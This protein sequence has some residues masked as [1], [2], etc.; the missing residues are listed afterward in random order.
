[1]IKYLK[2]FSLL[3]VAVLVLFAFSSCEKA[4][5]ELSD[6]MI[7]QGIGVDYEKGNYTVTVEIL[8][9]EQ[10]GSPSG[11]SASDNKTKIYSM[12][13]ETV[14]DALRLL[15][16]KSGNLPLFA[17][18]RVI[19]VN[20]NLNE[21]TISDVLEFFVRNYDSRASQLVC[22][23]KGKKAEDIIRA[24]LMN[25]TVKS[26]ILENL[27]TES[28]EHS[29]IPQVRVIDAVNSLSNKAM[30]LCIPA[31]SIKKNGE[32]E[33]YELA[34]CAIYDDKGKVSKFLTSE[35]AEGIAFLN[36]D[37]KEGFFTESL[38][39]GEKATFIINKSKTRFD[40]T[41][42]NGNLVYHLAVDISCDLDETGEK[43]R[44][45]KDAEILED[46]K[47]TVKSAV[48]RRVEGTLNALKKTDGGDCVRYCKILELKKPELYD[49]VED[50]WANIFI[51]AKTTVSV[52]VII[53]RVGEEILKNN[54][55]A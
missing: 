13:G 4:G 17:H 40:V 5:T 11:D 24:K 10:S 3:F 19:V 33:D 9:N 16:T 20:E 55:T 23:S 31:V 8:N 39:N 49:D 38:P 2:T 47:K 50:N 18:N 26:E 12:H 14:A 30:T 46:L 34:G 1:M 32:N 29:L 54:E 36:N 25:D 51:N 15:T 42:E 53:R 7:I 52:N 22:I 6:L 28:Y 45:K 27:L 44:Q 48:V 35:E 41:T 43:E 21:K 37:V